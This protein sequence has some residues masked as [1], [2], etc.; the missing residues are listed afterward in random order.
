M[1]NILFLF[2]FTFQLIPFVTDPESLQNL[3]SHSGRKSG[4]TLLKLAGATDSD[5]KQVGAWKTT[6]FFKYRFSILLNYVMNVLQN[7]T[8]A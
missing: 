1:K 8:Y 2:V 3:R 7:F 4:P 5:I 6:Y